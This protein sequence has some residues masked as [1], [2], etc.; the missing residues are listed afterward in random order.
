MSIKIAQLTQ[1]QL[2]G[3]L[4]IIR[5]S[6]HTVAEVY[7]LPA[8]NCVASG[9][10]IK[11]D[12]LMGDFRRGV[13]L[14]GCL[15]DGVSVGYMQM[16]MTEPGRYVLDKVAVLPEYRGKGIGAAMVDYATTYAIKHGGLKLTVSVFAI[17]TALIG[18]YQRHGFVLR[19]TVTKPGLPLEVACMEKDL[20]GLVTE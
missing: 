19:D 6:F 18:W 13:K 20:R 9:S 1:T 2:L 7:G 5:Q 3:Y 12:Q 16:E 17:D 15:C 8:E 11:M 10:F 4:S 14:F